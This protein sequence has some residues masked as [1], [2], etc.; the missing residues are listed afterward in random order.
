MVV[1]VGVF[2]IWV[3]FLIKEGRSW[4]Q[5]GWFKP[6][7]DKAREAKAERAEIVKEA[8][9]LVLANPVKCDKCG[10]TFEFGDTVVYAKD[11]DEAY[12][13]GEDPSYLLHI[14]C[15]I[16]YK[17][18]YDAVATVTFIFGGG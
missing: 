8:I 18:D 12:V 17:A 14:G 10:V 13:Y 2:C 3:G 9:G 7:S 15:F 4:E 11:S 5:W 1:V 6:R 16:G